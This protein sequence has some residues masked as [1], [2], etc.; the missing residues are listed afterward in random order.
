MASFVIKTFLKVLSFYSDCSIG[1]GKPT[2]ECVRDSIFFKISVKEVVRS[3]SVSLLFLQS[4][5]NSAEVLNITSWWNCT[6][7]CPCISLLQLSGL[8]KPL[9][10]K[11]KQGQVWLLFIT[12]WWESIWCYVLSMIP[13]G[14]QNVFKTVAS[15]GILFRFNLSR[16]R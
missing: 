1:A 8:V 4:K 3:L 14:Q 16:N 13:R 15:T 11:H 9:I 5:S 6:S 12:L 10:P 7:S 2:T